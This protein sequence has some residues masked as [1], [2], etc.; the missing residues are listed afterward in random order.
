MQQSATI[1]V[2]YAGIG[3]GHRIAAEAIAAELEGSVGVSRVE[4]VDVMSYGRLRVSPNSLTSAFTGPT[5]GLYDAIWSSPRMC[6]AA[7][8]VSGPVLSWLFAGFANHLASMRPDVVVA[9]HA[10]ASL[11]TLKRL[12]AEPSGPKVVN[13]A[14]D[15]GVHGFWP[16]KDVSLFCVA[17]HKTAG[18]LLERGFSEEQIAVTG[19]PVRP[20]FALDYDRL[21]ARRHFDL[22]ADKR[23]ILAVA[24]SA[25]PGPYERFK[26][27]LAVSLPALA[28]LPDSALVVVCG[29][30]EEFAQQ[31]RTRSAGFGTTNV[32]I[33]DYVDRMAPLMAAVDLVIGKPGGALCAE[34]LATEVP[35][36]LVGPAAG[37]ELANAQHLSD[38]GAAMYAQDPRSLAEYV[39]KVVSRPSRL[40]RMRQAA[41]SASKPFAAQDVATRVRALAGITAGPTPSSDPP[42]A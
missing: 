32:Q 18:D 16:R 10:L 35:M 30:D 1:A 20:Q 38:L 27:A 41:T 39:R 33:L 17:D 29:S 4:L 31:L 22:P 23:L 24:G 7:R 42:D 25:M 15:Y 40:E 28:S 8:N 9:T 14:T 6:S 37:Q 11:V 12:S 2:T 19:I 34:C 26:D 21:A 3:S 13:V 36:V 5:A